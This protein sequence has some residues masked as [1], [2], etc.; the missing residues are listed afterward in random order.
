MLII[1][2][3]FFLWEVVSLLALAALFIAE[4][5]GYI[6]IVVFALG[7][8]VIVVATL[9]RWGPYFLT[10]MTVDPT[11]NGG[12]GR[13][14]VERVIPA[15]NLPEQVEMSLQDAAEGVAEVNTIGVLNTIITILRPFRFLRVLSIGDLTLR[16]KSGAAKLTMYNIQ[17]PEG[18]KNRIQ[19]YWKEISKKQAA[20]KA[21]EEEE[22]FIRRMTV[23]V[24]QG[25][26]WA[27]NDEFHK[28][29]LSKD[30]TP[31]PPKTVPYKNLPAPQPQPTPE[32]NPT[33]QPKPPEE[34]PPAQ[35]P[36]NGSSHPT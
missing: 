6:D 34:P 29:W 35:P 28:F 10:R 15:P 13:V 17:D 3:E 1:R 4:L 24:A 21:Q 23:A 36:A 27:Q 8:A 32:E 11:A 12:N 22:A 14:S 20:K 33:A 30:G 7:V 2:P 9:W 31:E 19:A 25:L 5:F 16:T 18:V 26:R